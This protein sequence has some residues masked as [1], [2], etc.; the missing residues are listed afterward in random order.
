LTVRLFILVRHGQSVLNVA[1][2]VNGDPRRD[3]G[4]SPK[5]IEEAQALGRQIAALAVDVAVVSPFPR[6]AQTAD[7]ALEG[8][9]VP[10]IVDDDLGDIRLGELEGATAARYDAAKSTGDRN[11]RFPGGESLNEAAL[12]YVDAF[13]RLAASS[14]P[15]TLVVCHEFAVRYSVNAAGGSNDLEQPLH[16]VANATPYLFD[17]AGLQRAIL[18]MRE[19]AH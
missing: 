1:G 3:P 5:G 2:T 19:L 12:R 13:E 16:D 7:A 4:L 8:R 18:G 14:E 6:A 17:E 9:A 10:R 15:V 11:V